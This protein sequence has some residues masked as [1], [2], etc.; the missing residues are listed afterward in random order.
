MK[1]FAYL[2]LI[3]VLVWLVK[4]SYDVYTVT[5]QLGNLQNTLHRSEQKNATL[6][7]QLIALQRHPS[8]NEAES[9]KENSTPIVASAVKSLS[10]IV[11]IKQQLE[12][13]Q[14]AL[15][16]QQFV[17]AV[18]KLNELDNAV[19]LYDLSVAL[20][21]SLHQTIAQDKSSIQQFTLARQQ[22]IE[23]FDDV[24]LQL[25]Q[26]LNEQIGKE[27]LSPARPQVEHFWEKWFSL[28]KVDQTMPALANRHMVLKEVQIRVLSAQQSLVQGQ[29]HDYQ[30]MLDLASQQLE[31][32]P[33]EGSRKLAQ[34][35]VQ[36]KQLQMISIPKLN[37]FAV[38]G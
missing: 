8:A 22:Q 37:S 34:K 31:T 38:M 27:Q 7:D 26:Q 10:P 16:Q 17:Y 15:Q 25:D 28:E 12:L 6:N 3:L 9:K 20:K 33:D 36:L 18:E 30:K 21:Q 5:Q 1:K 11:L 2:L 14:F 35:I 23:K 29:M 32:L 19:E 13:I 4:L 24:L